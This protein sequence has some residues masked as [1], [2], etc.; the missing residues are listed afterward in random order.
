MARTL[1]FRLIIAGLAAALITAVA[2]P[3]PAGAA[4][5]GAPDTYANPL[6]QD[7]AQAFSDVGLIRAKDG[8]GTPTPPTRA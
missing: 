8:A 5:D 2:A 6:M 3:G 4:P 7:I 1:S